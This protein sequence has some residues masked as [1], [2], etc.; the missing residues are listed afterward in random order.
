M[1]LGIQRISLAPSKQNQ[2]W[3]A[4]WDYKSV[5]HH[6]QQSTL[7]CLVNLRTAIVDAM[8][9]WGQSFRGS[10]SLRKLCRYRKSI[11]RGLKSG[12]HPGFTWRVWTFNECKWN[13]CVEAAVLIKGNAEV[14]HFLQVVQTFLEASALNVA[15]VWARV[16]HRSSFWALWNAARCVSL[17]RLKL[18]VSGCVEGMSS[19]LQAGGGGWGG[20]QRCELVIY[21]TPSTPASI[22]LPDHWAGCRAGHRRLLR[23]SDLLSTFFFFLLFNGVEANKETNGYLEFM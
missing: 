19:R 21:T 23:Q 16:D 18:Q 6:H 10:S 11:N 12:L 5:G 13:L 8:V 20:K 9:S 14:K 15:D 4:L 17:G 2:M 3:M 7:E 1:V 22:Q